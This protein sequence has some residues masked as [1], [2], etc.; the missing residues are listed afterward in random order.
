MHATHP[1]CA[2][3]DGLLYRCAIALV[4]ALRGLAAGLGLVCLRL[5]YTLSMQCLLVRTRM[6]AETAAD[7]WTVMRPAASRQWV[8]PRPP[9]R[10]SSC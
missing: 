9:S 3:I 8:A 10:G 5:V 7:A 4:L 2:W 1:S 6:D